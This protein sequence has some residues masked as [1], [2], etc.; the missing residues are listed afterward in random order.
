ML[1]IIPTITNEDMNAHFDAIDAKLT[2]YE[3]LKKNHDNNAHAF[4]FFL[5]N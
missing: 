1:R 2:G 3:V 5:H 4:L